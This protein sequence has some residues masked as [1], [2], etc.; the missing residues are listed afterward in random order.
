MNVVIVYRG[1]AGGLVDGG[2]PPPDGAYLESFDPEYY[3]GIGVAEWTT[4]PARAMRFE[5]LGEA[6]ELYKRQSVERPLRD[7]MEPNRPM[8]A[9]TVEFTSLLDERLGSDEVTVCPTHLRFVPCRRCTPGQETYSTD[10]E[11][12]RRTTEYQK[13]E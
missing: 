13:G 9:Y 3:T 6:I 12:V 2:P 4:D 8:T 7:D 11:D 10:P 1:L 5:T